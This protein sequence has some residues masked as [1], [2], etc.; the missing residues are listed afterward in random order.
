MNIKRI[1]LKSPQ[2]ILV[3]EVIKIDH[4][5]IHVLVQVKHML[6]KLLKDHLFGKH[7]QLFHEHL[8][9]ELVFLL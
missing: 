4:N 9:R 6:L 8:H 1:K 5:F 2:L 3:L 7:Q